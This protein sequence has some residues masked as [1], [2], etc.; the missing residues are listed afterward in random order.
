MED[1][2]KTT[3]KTYYVCRDCSKKMET[4]SVGS[5]GLDFFGV[6]SNGKAMYCN[7]KDCPKFGYLTVAGIKKE[8]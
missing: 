8:E 6:T 5:S 1:I 4:M 3:T 2:T 7:D